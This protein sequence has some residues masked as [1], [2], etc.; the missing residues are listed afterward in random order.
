MRKWLGSLL[1]MNS[2]SS[3]R[4]LA[5]VTVKKTMGNVFYSVLFLESFH[6]QGYL[7]FDTGS[8]R[9]TWHIGGD[10]LLSWNDESDYVADLVIDRLRLLDRSLRLYF[11]VAACIGAR[12]PSTSVCSIVWNTYEVEVDNTTSD[13]LVTL[14]LIESDVD[15]WEKFAH[16][17]IQKAALLNPA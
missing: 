5:D 10:V 7:R 3:T 11:K 4:Q 9:W 14:G 16:D 2:D 8:A 15:G 17:C 12:F 13:A 1:G 6:E